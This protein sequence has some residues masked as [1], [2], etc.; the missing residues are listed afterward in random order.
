MIDVPDLVR[1][2]DVAPIGN[3]D[4]CSLSGLFDGWLFQ[5]EVLVGKIYLNTKFI[6]IQLVVRYTILPGVTFGLLTILFR[7]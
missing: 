1:I 5:T 2:A 4:D 7:F 3:S 6:E